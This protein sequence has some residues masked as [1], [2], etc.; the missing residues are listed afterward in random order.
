M[1]KQTVGVGSTAND[2]T[3]DSLRAGF[4]K[5]NDNFTELY[6][7]I[8]TTP[9][10]VGLVFSE[11]FEGSSYDTDVIR[12]FFATVTHDTGNDRLTLTGTNPAIRLDKTTLGLEVGQWYS[13]VIEWD[14]NTADMAQAVGSWT[15]AAAR[16]TFY[17][18]GVTGVLIWQQED[19]T[20]A[21]VSPVVL[22]RAATG[23]SCTAYINDI[24]LYAGV[25][26]Y[27]NQIY[28]DGPLVWGEDVRVTNSF[29]ANGVVIGNDIVVT[30][31][32]GGTHPV[33][34]GSEITG[35]GAIDACI[36][37]GEG[38]SLTSDESF[39]G[40]NNPERV[41]IGRSAQ[42]GCWRNTVVGAFAHALDTSA[43]AWGFGACSEV[44]HG[45]ALSRGAYIPHETGEANLTLFADYDLVLG[46]GTMHRCDQS[47]A[48]VKYGSA[49]TTEEDTGVTPS[50]TECKVRG[51]D[52]F[53]ARATPSD[54]N[55]AG[56]HIA[57]CAGR[58]TGSGV[59]GKVRLQTAP[60]GSSGAAKNAW[61]TAI[62]VDAVATGGSEETR[63]LLLDLTDGT[64]K[65]VSFGA[66]DSAGTGFKT[67]RVAN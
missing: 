36:A 66:D 27:V 50:G 16:T 14:A 28:Q 58:G 5:V 37:I 55:I 63:F 23:S 30:L 51:K 17:N 52:A 43:S 39:G 56:G 35:S 33:L 22:F 20:D 8:V 4:V 54:T 34:I 44:S 31:T 40:S 15:N 64:L 65:R 47:P 60:A 67:L 62:E 11:N 29:L 48:S 25:V 53:D 46:N 19:G 61:A 13:L 12:Q 7:P 49:L 2:G 21:N 57:V 59:G 18:D 6:G 10:P 26:G 32:G 3:G 45:N 41:V 42:A 38:A 9:V 24:K 1:A